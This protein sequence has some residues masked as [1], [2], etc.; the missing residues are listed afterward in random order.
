MTK[1]SI[2]KTKPDSVSWLTDNGMCWII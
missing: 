2:I 1:N